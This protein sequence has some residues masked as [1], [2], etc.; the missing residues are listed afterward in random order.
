MSMCMIVCDHM[1]QQPSTPTTVE[2]KEV[3]LRKKESVND[4]N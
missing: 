3:G 4:R 1:Q 2:K